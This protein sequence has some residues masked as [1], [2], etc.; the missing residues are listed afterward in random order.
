M[1]TIGYSAFYKS[2][3][4]YEINIPNSVTTIETYAF[5]DNRNLK[6]V[7]LGNS[8]TSIGFGAFCYCYDLHNVTFPNSLTTI[9]GR[10]F[11]GCISYVTDIRIP[12]SVSSIDSE[13]FIG[14]KSV[15]TMT[16]DSDNPYYD[17]RNN[18]N[19]IIETATNT[20]VSGCSTTIIPNTVKAIGDDAFKMC[21]NLTRVNIP[22]SVISIGIMSYYECS[23]VKRISIGEAVTSIANGAFSYCGSVK[24]VICKAVVPPEFT[25]MYI[26]NLAPFSSSVYNSATLFVPKGSVQAYKEAN[27]WKKFVNICGIGDLVGDMD[28]DCD[29]TITDAMVLINYL[30]SGEEEG[31]P[32]EVADVNGDGYVNI[33]DVTALIN[34]LLANGE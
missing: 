6:N 20:L 34:Q 7:Y 9:G 2:N 10:V 4:L 14:C 13:A 29:L 24:K 21:Y 12:A 30:L 22:D 3:A 28:G 33:S 5:R 31:V 18:C 19:A 27:I 11:Y 25:H 17:S 8:V 32:V 1:V 23:S 16:V 26:A 15:T